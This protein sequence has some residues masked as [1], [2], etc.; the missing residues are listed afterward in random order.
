MRY[1]LDLSAERRL[2]VLGRTNENPP[3]RHNGRSLSW[4][5]LLLIVSGTCTCRIESRTFYAVRGDIV[6]IP[7]GKYYKLS[8]TDHCE[9]C[10]A[11]FYAGY[12]P[13]DEADIS[14]M[15]KKLPTPEKKFFLPEQKNRVICIPDH[16][17][18][19]D[20]DYAKLLSLFTRCQM[21]EASGNCFDRI[22]IDTCFD[23]LLLYVSG[24]AFR[25]PMSGTTNLSLE[26]MTRYIG[27]HFN[28]R[29]SLDTLAKKF[30]LSKEH[31][32]ALFRSGF[33]MTVSEYVNTV[34][35][36]HATELLSNSSM[37]ISQ[38]A[39]YLGYSSVYYF[40]RVFKARFGAS[41]SKYKK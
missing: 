38:I 8:T 29:I 1:K 30:G 14:E 7:A 32:C 26:R 35:L 40:S 19:P 24:A 36:E 9:Y 2:E 12:Q 15:F 41:P 37:N 4:N 31:I 11:C 39:D 25:N 5:H 18:L 27:E 28:E 21:L 13:A 16:V 3:W 22:L 6:F 10:F 23:A 20:T 17:R 33:D 34:K